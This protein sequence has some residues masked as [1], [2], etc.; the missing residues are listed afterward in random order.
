MYLSVIVAICN[1]FTAHDDVL[2]RPVVYLP[3]FG[4]R[5]TI[6]TATLHETCG[7]NF[8][9]ISCSWVVPVLAFWS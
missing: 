7:L 3:S 4:P 6:W 2:D 8:E 9:N 5:W 1:I